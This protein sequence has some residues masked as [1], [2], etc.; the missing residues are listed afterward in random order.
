M[1]SRFMIDLIVIQNCKYIMSIYITS[2]LFLK[3]WPDPM[4]FYAQRPLKINIWKI[5][6]LGFEIK[7]AIIISYNKWFSGN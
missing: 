4:V 3:N 1:G 7:L 6:L 2:V 5:Q